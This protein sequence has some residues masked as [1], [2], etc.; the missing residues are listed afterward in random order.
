MADYI[1][2][3]WSC[4][5]VQDFWCKICDAIFDITTYRIQQQPET[6]LLHSWKEE[7]PWSREQTIAILLILAKMEIASKWK[8]SKGP[9]ITSWC[10]RIWNSFVMSKIID[11]LMR[12]MHVG[13]KSHLEEVWSEILQFLEN[14]KIL[15]PAAI[16]HFFHNIN[17]EYWIRIYLSLKKQVHAWLFSTWER[18]RGDW[19]AIP[20]LFAFLESVGEA[21][22]YG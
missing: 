13:Y 17:G 12:E 9:T 19:G 10:N 15:P 3:W 5:Q 14:L 2:C 11:K 1:H 16:S 21:A 22:S 4:P 8:D 7:L 20:P 18:G 6:V